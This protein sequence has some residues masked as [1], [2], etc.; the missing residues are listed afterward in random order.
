MTPKPELRQ[1]LE[2]PRPGST[3][4]GIGVISGWA[5]HAN[6]VHIL[7]RPKEGGRWQVLEATYGTIRADTRKICRDTDNGFGLLF[8]WNLLGDGDFEVALRING[9][10]KA[11]ADIEV[12]TFGEEFMRDAPDTRFCFSFPT[13]EEQTCLLRWEESKQNFI[14]VGVE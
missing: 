9:S 5:C 3:Q 14:I 7:I 4:S 11:R 12:V 6:R 8:N 13:P 2:N 1:V 10:I